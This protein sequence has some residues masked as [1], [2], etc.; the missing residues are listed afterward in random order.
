MVQKGAR[1]DIVDS[2][3]RTPLDMVR[4]LP[5]SETA[6]TIKYEL[7]KA[8]ASQGR[9]QNTTNNYQ[10]RPQ[11]EQRIQHG[12]SGQTGGAYYDPTFWGSQRSGIKS[13]VNPGKIRAADKGVRS[14]KS[15]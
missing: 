10:Y 2:L 7:E 12:F 14:Q 9:L 13:Q 4:E 3:G 6:P 5:C 8:Q 1:V 11:A 15:K